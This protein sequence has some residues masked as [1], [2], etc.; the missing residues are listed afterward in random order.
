MNYE[1]IYKSKVKTMQG[2]L[3][4]IK[5]NDFIFTAQAGSEPMAI[6]D[7]LHSV[8]EKGVRGCDLTNCFPIKNYEFI[9]NPLYKDT[10]YV[11]G[12]FYTAPLR[13]SHPNGNVCLVPQ[14]AHSALHKRIFASEGRRLVLLCTCSPMDTHGFLTLSLSSVYERELIDMGALV[15]AEVNP[16][17]PRTFGDTAVH[18]SEVAALV[19]VDYPVPSIPPAPYTEVDKKIG[20]YIADLVED[21]STIQLG[22]G[23][24]PNAVASELKNK[25][26]LGI[27]TEMFTDSM[28]DLI[29]CGAIDNSMKCL[30]KGKSVG[31]FAFG[32]ERLYKF[33]DDNP[34][35]IFKPASWANDPYVVGQNY[36]MVSI[37]TSLEVDLTGQCASESIGHLQYSGTGGQ[38]DTAIG[39]QMS[40]GGKSI[41]ALHSTAETTDSDGKKKLVSKISPLLRE[42]TVISL[43]RNDVDYVVTEYGAA[44]LRGRS[45]KDRVERLISIAHPDFRDELKHAAEENMLW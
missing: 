34:S 1:E 25:K 24:I 43:S 16:N 40:E 5:S 44:W 26:H 22:I 7:N 42:G 38:A 15:I 9:K 37:N 29:E 45:V 35:F 18:V 19:E 39:A 3:D 10:I 2:A 41:I 21:G 32:S 33:I 14:H 28:A 6:L 27:H 36:K 31:C 13:K 8:R 4:L 17:F 20:E 11:N 12:W 30:Y 23:K